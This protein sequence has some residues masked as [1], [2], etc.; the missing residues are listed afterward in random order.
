M[1]S[2]ERM[3]GGGFGGQMG[4][5]PMGGQMG[6]FG[7]GGGMG[8]MGGMGMPGAMSGMGSGPAAWAPGR[9]GRR[10]SGAGPRST[11][12]PA[13]THAHSSHSA[14]SSCRFWE[15]TRSATRA[16]ARASRT[17][18]SARGFTRDD[19]AFVNRTITPSLLAA[20]RYTIPEGTPELPGLVDD[21]V[22]VGEGGAKADGGL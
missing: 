22:P 2:R 9:A 18:R 13:A 3:F 16:P 19:L 6:M 21:G 17:R 11:S 8:P 20:L 14:A 12:R 5:F 10:K 1:P 15:T 7:M 4:L